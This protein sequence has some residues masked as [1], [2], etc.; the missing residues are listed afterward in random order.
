MVYDD[1]GNNGN[2]YEGNYDGSDCAN[3]NMFVFHRYFYYLIFDVVLTLITV[4]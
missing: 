3:M 1:Y 2:N 4:I